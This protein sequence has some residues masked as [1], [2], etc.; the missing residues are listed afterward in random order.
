M[1]VGHWSAS[2]R[3]FPWSYLLG[4]FQGAFHMEPSRREGSIFAEC[5]FFCKELLFCLSLKFFN[6]SGTEVEMFLNVHNV[7]WSKLARNGLP[8]INCIC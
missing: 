3:L 2:K 6:F 5:T 8:D 4:A 7:Y 1:K